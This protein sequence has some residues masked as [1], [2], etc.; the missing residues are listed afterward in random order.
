MSADLVEDGRRARRKAALDARAT[1]ERRSLPTERA[2]TMPCPATA[3]KPASSRLE[4]TTP[5]IYYAWKSASLR[6]GTREIQ[7]S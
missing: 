3:I 5:R 2:A 7:H 1:P 4:F 6:S